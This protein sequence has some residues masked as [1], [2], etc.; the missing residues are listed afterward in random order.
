M[1]LMNK[2]ILMNINEIISRYSLWPWLELLAH[3]M[4][5]KILLNNYHKVVQLFH[6]I[7]ITK[8]ILS[9]SATINLCRC[10]ILHLEAAIFFIRFE[11]R[12]KLRH[13]D[14]SFVIS[15]FG[16]P[17]SIWVNACTRNGSCEVICNK[18][19]NISTVTQEN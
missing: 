3:K 16:L 15:F 17:V 4:L 7:M 6:A 11:A 9:Y 19:E 12:S 10:R 5:S 1:M 18:S 8:L 2:I 14:V 13:E